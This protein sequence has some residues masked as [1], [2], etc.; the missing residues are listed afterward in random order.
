MNLYSKEFN[1]RCP[2][3]EVLTFEIYVMQDLEN[4]SAYTAK[5]AAVTKEVIHP[6]NVRL[7]E[8][9]GLDVETY[10][11]EFHFRRYVPFLLTE[12]IDVRINRK[13][14]NANGFYRKSKKNRKNGRL[15]EHEIKD[16]TCSI[17][18]SDEDNLI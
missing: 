3:D 6:W 4:Q 18:H 17:F 12:V 16:V 15:L 9:I 8:Q 5:L 13:T 14:L 7:K 2:I 11:N 1:L 10:P